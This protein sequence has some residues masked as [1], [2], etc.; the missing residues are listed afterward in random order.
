MPTWP[1]RLL[2]PSHLR[3]HLTLDGGIEPGPRNQRAGISVATASVETVRNEPTPF[4]FLHLM[5]PPCLRQPPRARVFEGCHGSQGLVSHSSLIL[6]F[7]IHRF[8]TCLFSFFRFCCTTHSKPFALWPL[9]RLLPGPQN[10]WLTT[11][12]LC[13]YV[14]DARHAPPSLFSQ[15]PCSSRG[16]VV[17]AGRGQQATL[18][19]V[20]H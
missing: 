20:A 14:V 16:F 2:A 5:P 1:W 19:P 15:R 11:D 18:N 13:M 7:I 9:A 12:F 10:K 17:A 4:F 3:L 6:S 8:P